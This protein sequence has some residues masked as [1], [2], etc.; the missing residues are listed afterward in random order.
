MQAARSAA[1]QAEREVGELA[2][3]VERMRGSAEAQVRVCIYV[4][5]YVYIYIYIG[6]VRRARGR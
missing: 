6:R 5:V 1:E 3:E 2:A 4:Y